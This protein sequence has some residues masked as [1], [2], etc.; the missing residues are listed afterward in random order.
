MLKAYKFLKT[1]IKFKAYYIISCHL[2]IVGYLI[3]S[4][5]HTPDIR[6][7]K[8]KIIEFMN[9]LIYSSNIWL[10]I[11]YKLTIL[12]INYLLLSMISILESGV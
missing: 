4:P 9:I 5:C 7:S 6:N 10:M 12:M 8:G 2:Y 1:L 3:G 11:K